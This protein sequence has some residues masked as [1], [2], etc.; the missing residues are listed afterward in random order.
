MSFEE[1]MWKY[2]MNFLDTVTITPDIIGKVAIW[3]GL[4]LIGMPSWERATK[5]AQNLEQT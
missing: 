4:I 1:N 3:L 5:N 2:R